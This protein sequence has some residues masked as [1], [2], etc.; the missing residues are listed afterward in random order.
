MAII[1][2]DNISKKY[3]EH[4]LYES[5][6]LSIE[7]GTTVGIV[8]INGSGKS[9][10]FKLIIGLEY[11]DAGNIYVRGKK[12]GK[13]FDFPENVG[14]FVNRPGYIDYYDGFR[15]LKMLAEIQNKIDEDTIRLYMKKLGLHPDDK[16]KVKNYSE[17]MKQKLG[18][19]Q[20][21]MEGQD[22]ILLDEP[23]NALDFQTNREVISLLTT[24]KKEKKT[25]LLTSHQHEYLEKICD[26]LYFI[27]DKKLVPFNEEIKNTY[28]NLY[29][30]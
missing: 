17:G 24:L 21:I 27:L 26:Q 23:F 25:I 9:V 20:A 7:E 28:F 2:L 18:I 16:K 14:I 12:V 13:G 15:N 6:C 4:V 11:A 29:Q 3:N 30:V 22:I 19:T 10:L 5:A 8:G 1:K